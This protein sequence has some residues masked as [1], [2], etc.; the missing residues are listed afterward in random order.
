MHRRPSLLASLAPAARRLAGRAAPAVLDVAGL[1][2]LTSAAVVIALPLGL[3]VAGVSCFVLQW[4][5]TS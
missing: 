2:L 4:R 1:G 5:L 3:A